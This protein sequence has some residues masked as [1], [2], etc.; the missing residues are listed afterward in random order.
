MIPRRTGLGTW[1]TNLQIPSEKVIKVENKEGLKPIDAATITVNPITAWRMLTD[2]V[3]L[4]AE[5]GDWFIQNGANSGVGRAAL[6][7]GKR[8]GYKSIAVIRDRPGEEGVQLKKELEELGATQVV[9]EQE[10]LER[11][12]KDKIKE[13]TNGGRES[14][15]L[16]LNC[17]GGKPTLSLAKVLEDGGCVVTYGAMA[18]QPLTIPASLLIFKNLNFAGFWVSKWGDRNPEEK[19]KVV[20]ELFDM[21]KSEEFKQ[22]PVVEVPWN[23][24]TGKEELVQ[25]VQGTLEGFRRGKGVY[26]FGDE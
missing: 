17:V 26:V 9:T 8:W 2:F 15:K 19:E 25:A 14:L 11:D 7:L 24:K 13:W 12:F 21:I 22:G 18:K 4:D 6:Q 3:K 16:A 5:K 23:L 20:N 1:R 10:T